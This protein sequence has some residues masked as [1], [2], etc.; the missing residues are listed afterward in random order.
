MGMIFFR[1][2][3]AL[4]FVFVVFGTES[5]AG[6]AGKP[7][8]VGSEVCG[9]C[10]YKAFKSW[11]KTKLSRALLVLGP[12]K[13]TRVKRRLGL[14]P[15]RDYSRA[16]ECLKCHTTGFENK[17]GKFTFS[18]YG[19]G[20][21]ACHGPGEKYSKIMRMQGRR[22]KREDLVKAGLRIDLKDICMSCHNQESPY[23]GPG[24]EFKHS[25]RYD[26]VHIP[27]HLKYHKQVERGEKY[28]EEQ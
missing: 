22:Y 9:S 27:V 20:C 6:T 18:E 8:Y 14:D 23:I 26:K 1:T 16:P 15:N 21:E 13:A 5:S 10:H 7:G 3:I 11:E 28:E 25:E 24:Y 2:V 4:F 12:K 19:I 17:D